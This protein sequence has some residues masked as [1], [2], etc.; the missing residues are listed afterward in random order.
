MRSFGQFLHRQFGMQVVLGV[1]QCSL[2]TVGFGFEVEH[3]REL[4]LPTGTTVIDH[5]LSGNRARHFATEVLIGPP[6]SDNSVT[7]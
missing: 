3:H 1:D 7:S 6:S 2:D 4:R 5:Q